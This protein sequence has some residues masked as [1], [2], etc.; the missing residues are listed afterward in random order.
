MFKIQK[1]SEGHQNHSWN[2]NDCS[3]RKNSFKLQK[4]VVAGMENYYALLLQFTL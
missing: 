4:N 2:F 3:N 1:Q